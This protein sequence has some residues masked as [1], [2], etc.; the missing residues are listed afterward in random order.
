MSSFRGTAQI[1]SDRN[2]NQVKHFFEL[3]PE[4]IKQIKI[5][6]AHYGDYFHLNP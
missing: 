1:N 4:L 5:P 6:P 2:K 3:K